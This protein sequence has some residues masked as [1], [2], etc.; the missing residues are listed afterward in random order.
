MYTPLYNQ[1]YNCSCKAK[2]EHL[3]ALEP[4]Y[5]ISLNMKLFLVEFS[6]QKYS[7]N[8]L[9]LSLTLIFDRHYINI[10]HTEKNCVSFR[11]NGTKP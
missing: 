4:C 11:G 3:S 9:A 2:I 5:L 8:I 6:L 10:F 7:I 1:V